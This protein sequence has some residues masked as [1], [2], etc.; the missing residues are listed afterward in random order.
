MWVLDQ[1]FAAVKDGLLS[2]VHPRRRAVLHICVHDRATPTDSFDALDELVAYAAFVGGLSD[3][4]RRCEPLMAHELLRICTSVAQH[5]LSFGHPQMPLETAAAL[6]QSWLT[7]FDTRT[8]FFGNGSEVRE[9]PP[10]AGRSLFHTDL[11]AG[12]VAMSRSRAGLFWN[13]ENS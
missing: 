7:R 11:E 1:Q 6:A 4:V 3:D 12:V 8:I 2:S 9:N 13:A 10:E 5:E